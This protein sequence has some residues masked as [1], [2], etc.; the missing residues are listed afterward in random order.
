MKFNIKLILTIVLLSTS[1]FAQDATN[2]ISDN[3]NTMA[4]WIVF[5]VVVIPTIIFIGSLYVKFKNKVE[6]NDD[7]NKLGTQNHFSE[8]LK[9][10]SKI[11]VQK[12]LNLKNNTSSTSKKS[13]SNKAKL[14]SVLLLTSTTLLIGT[15]LSIQTKL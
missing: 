9:S 6:E 3:S 1:T 12:L 5:F 14:L 13:T 15:K 4:L 7:W 10:L 2:I 8:Y 11:Q